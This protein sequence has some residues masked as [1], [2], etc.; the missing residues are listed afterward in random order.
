MAESPARERLIDAATRLFASDGYHAV[1]ISRIL[2]E[3][4]VSRVALY[5][6][7]RSKEELILAVLRHRDEVTRN[8]IM[9]EVEQASRSPRERLLALFDFL[10][11][12][13]GQPDFSGCMFL[14]AAAEYHDDDDPI[15]RISAEHKK[16]LLAF[17]ERQCTAA[18]AQEPRQLAHQI[19]MLFDGAIVQIHT[20]GASAER[21]AAAKTAAAALLS[22]SATS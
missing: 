3:A 11:R 5:H 22:A 1:G 16:M 8:L 21:I 20:A 10:D 2:A 4:G 17:I 15:H 9:R 13:V 12:Y 7:F 14:N 6:H 18:G 19:Y